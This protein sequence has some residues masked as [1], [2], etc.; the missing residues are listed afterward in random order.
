MKTENFDEEGS[1]NANVMFQQYFSII[2]SQSNAKNLCAECNLCE[3]PKH[4]R[5]ARTSTSNF[6]RPIRVC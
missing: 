1:L 6:L 3:G 5:G 2:D 4:V